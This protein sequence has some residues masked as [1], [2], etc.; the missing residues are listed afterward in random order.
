MRE[1]FEFWVMT[2]FACI[3]I[4]AIITALTGLAK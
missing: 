4:A 3:A 1:E 2:I